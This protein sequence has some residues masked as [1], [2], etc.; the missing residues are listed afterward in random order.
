MPKKAKAFKNLLKC[1]IFSMDDVKS[2]AASSTISEYIPQ[3]VTPKPD[4]AATTKTKMEAHM[5]IESFIT[6]VLILDK[7]HCWQLNN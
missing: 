2:I 1:I 4:A 7:I 3:P 5:T 6:K